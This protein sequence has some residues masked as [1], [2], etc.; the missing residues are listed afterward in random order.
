MADIGII[1]RDRSRRRRRILT[2]IGVAFGLLL[3]VLAATGV[4]IAGRPV[5]GTEGLIAQLEM[6]I[7]VLQAMFGLAIALSTIYYAM[8]TSDMVATMQAGLAADRSGQIDATVSN[9]VAAA[10]RSASVCGAMAG[11][12]QRS[13]RWHL[14]AAA[15]SR[16]RFAEST[17]SELIRAVS[18]VAR[19]AEEVAYRAPDLEGLAT[20]LGS[21]VVDLQDAALHGRVEE[22]HAQSRQLRAR[23]DELR[24]ACEVG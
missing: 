4:Q 7:A 3:A 16:D 13:W 21:A 23:I 10:L 8:R 9:L 11:L 18:D 22:T 15:A 14:P 24:I 12:M 19:W 20:A 6:L 2:A 5:R 17:L 1:E